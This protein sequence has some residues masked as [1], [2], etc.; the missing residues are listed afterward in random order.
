MLTHFIESFCAEINMKQPIITAG[1]VCRHTHMNSTQEDLAN[2]I[3]PS[4]M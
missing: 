2:T 3:A 1:Y 4:C